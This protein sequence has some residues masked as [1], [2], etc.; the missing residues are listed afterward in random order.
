MGK[1]ERKNMEWME[2]EERGMNV[3]E[4]R[5]GKRFGDLA[6]EWM[7][8]TK[9]QW[10]ES[11]NIKYRNMLESYILPYLGGKNAE[12]LTYPAMMDYCS[13]LLTHG[14]MQH[15]G[16]SSKTVS[17]VMSVVRNVLKFAERNG[18]PVRELGTHVLI[19][20]HSRS[21]RILSRAEQKK[22]CNYLFAHPEDGRNLGILISL[23]TGLR[24]GEV[25]ALSWQDISLEERTLTV[26]HT[27]QRI[28]AEEDGGRKT[29]III[30]SPKSLCSVRIIP[31]PEELS[32]LLESTGKKDRGYL[33]SGNSE[34]VIEP[35]SMQYH[36]KKVLR[37]CQIREANYHCLRHTFATRCVELGFD[38]KSLSEILG[39]ASVNITMNRYVHPSME[40]KRKNMSKLSGLMTS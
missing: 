15:T 14:G 13:Y 8:V 5:S 18:C 12:D 11:T 24:L 38:V 36:F 17:D 26:H 9:T 22:I 1:E 35:R 34:K 32:A 40:L 10:K 3:E 29:K 20:Q 30:S 23:F 37:H 2:K 28:Q 6:E 16:L 39:H 19:R 31:I 33:L 25:C 21:M 4:C 7:A 27:M